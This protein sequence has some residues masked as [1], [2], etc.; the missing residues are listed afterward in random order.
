VNFCTS[1]IQAT[2]CSLLIQRFRN[3]LNSK[4]RK[5]LAIFGKKCLKFPKFCGKISKCYEN[6]FK[7]MRIDQGHQK[8]SEKSHLKYKH[9]V[10]MRK[11]TYFHKV[12]NVQRLFWTIF[13][14]VQTGLVQKNKQ[15]NSV[16]I[17]HSR[18]FDIRVCRSSLYLN[19]CLKIVT[20]CIKFVCAN[21]RKFL[22]AH[23]LMGSELKKH[24][25]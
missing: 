13:V 11:N 18:L 9:I 21:G 16:K 14:H 17:C 12:Q 22:L 6:F 7:V 24:H 8:M 3:L 4:N 25:Y 1:V 5:K 10:F 2:L 15:W 19:L 20:T 23:W